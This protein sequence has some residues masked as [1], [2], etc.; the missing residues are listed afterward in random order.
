MATDADSTAGDEE[1]RAESAAADP[2]GTGEPGDAADPQSGDADSLAEP[3][4]RA[5]AGTRESVYLARITVLRLRVT[6][7]ESELAERERDLQTVRDRYERLLD[8]P[9][10]YPGDPLEDFEARHT[11]RT[12]GGRSVAHHDSGD[13]TDSGVLAQLGGLRDRLRGLFSG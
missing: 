5:V 4:G 12:D 9:A 13:G 1:R 8:G 10:T 3:V 6:E 2:T 7:L 11:E